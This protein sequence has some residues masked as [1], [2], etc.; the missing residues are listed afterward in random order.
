MRG[1]DDVALLVDA[2]NILVRAQKAMERV[3]LAHGGVPTAAILVFVN[4]LSRWI[5][6]V[7]PS[8]VVLCW[9]GG[10]S[11]YRHGVYSS[12]KAARIHGHVEIEGDPPDPFELA[13]LFCELAKIQSVKVRGV[14]ADDLIAHYWRNPDLVAGSRVVIL[15]G[16]KDFLQLLDPPTTQIRPGDNKGEWWDQRRVK[17]EMGV[18]PANLPKVMALTGDHID[19]IPGVP[20]FGIKTAV[21]KLVEHDWSLTDL[22]TSGDEKVVGYADVVARN[23]KLVDLRNQGPDLDLKALQPF[24]PATPETSYGEVLLE[25]LEAL[26]LASLA[27]RFRAGEL[28]A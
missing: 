2:N 26:G 19:G 4:C 15:S 11:D 22:M 28:W 21:K 23:L 14:E 18:T 8:H 3:P 27:T 12:Y 7:I 1:R 24:D 16:D 25:F 5:R 20:K 9:D 10:G 17:E 6:E 13:D